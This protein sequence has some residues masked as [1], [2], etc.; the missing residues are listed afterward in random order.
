[1]TYID[2]NGCASKDTTSA[3]DH[4]AALCDG[5][6]KCS[7]YTTRESSLFHAKYAS[8]SYVCKS[9]YTS[10]LLYCINMITISP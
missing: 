3:K 2:D 1:M 9:E 10:R 6:R 8:V 7:P 4:I 5:K